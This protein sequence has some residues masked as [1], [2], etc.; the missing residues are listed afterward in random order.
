MKEK[1][2]I[3]IVGIVLGNAS[4]YLVCLSLMDSRIEADNRRQ[5]VALKKI[6]APFTDDKISASDD[7]VEVIGELFRL[8]T[9][10]LS[11]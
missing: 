11:D 3:L 7:L 2:I 5:A 9:F 6:L 1:I 4:S 10:D 8:P